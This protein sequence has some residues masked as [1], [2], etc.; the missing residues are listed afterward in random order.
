[1][2]GEGEGAHLR[3]FANEQIL[4]ECAKGTAHKPCT[5]VNKFSPSGY[6]LMILM[7]YMCILQL[8]E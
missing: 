5:V 4:K 7:L 1:M 3:N 8:D 6:K 2:G